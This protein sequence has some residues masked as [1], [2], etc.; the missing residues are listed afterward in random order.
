MVGDMGA[1]TRVPGVREWEEEDGNT[2]QANHFK[3]RDVQ[4]RCS[5]CLRHGPSRGHARRE[6]GGHQQVEGTL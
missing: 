5:L 2:H 3:S 6:P 4:S 1:G